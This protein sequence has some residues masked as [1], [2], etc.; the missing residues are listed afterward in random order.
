M[1]LMCSRS[2]DSRTPV[3]MPLTSHVIQPFPSTI[4]DHSYDIPLWRL[5][6]LHL[7]E[8]VCTYSRYCTVRRARP[9]DRELH[10]PSEVTWQDD[11]TWEHKRWH[12]FS[13]LASTWTGLEELVFRDGKPD[14]ATYSHPGPTWLGHPEIPP[15]YG[16]S[17]RRRRAEGPPPATA[18]TCFQ[19]E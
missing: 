6:E 16:K 3:E 15:R 14:L 10:R 7:R 12:S 9:S 13:I 18:V 8:Y 2:L 17:R 19:M 5:R 11:D 1:K 4:I